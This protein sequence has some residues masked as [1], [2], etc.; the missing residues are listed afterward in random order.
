MGIIDITLAVG[1]S[2]SVLEMAEK[3]LR[4]LFHEDE[5][6]PA[7][8]VGG[9]TPICQFKDFTTGG[10]A[11]CRH[12]VKWYENVFRW[13]TRVRAADVE[14]KMSELVRA[15]NVGFDEEKSGNQSSGPWLV[16]KG[17]PWQPVIKRKSNTLV[18]NS[19]VVLAYL[20]MAS[21]ARAPPELRD[22]FLKAAECEAQNILDKSGGSFGCP[23]H[24]S[25]LRTIALIQDHDFERGSQRLFVREPFG[26]HD[27]QLS[28]QLLDCVPECPWIPHKSNRVAVLAVDGIA[29]DALSPWHD[30]VSLRVLDIQ[31]QFL[32]RGGS[33]TQDIIGRR[34][35][36][37]GTSDDAING[38]RGLA[39]SYDA[40]KDRYQVELGIVRK[41]DGPTSSTPK[42]VS[43]RAA[44]V[45]Q[46]H[47]TPPPRT[48]AD[49]APVLRDVAV[50]AFGTSAPSKSGI[51]KEWQMMQ[52]CSVCGVT[53]EANGGKLSKCAK[54]RYALYCSHECQVAGW[55]THRKKCKEYSRIHGGESLANVSRFIANSKGILDARAT[56]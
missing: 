49:A 18:G 23:A 30:A 44:C 48:V 25:R 8:W 24:V 2:D 34:V 33:I 36:V 41:A 17:D 56:L 38:R 37:S 51:R 28:Y 21:G 14:T 54:C 15:A 20:F 4:V 19:Y 42:V 29:P 43:L 12:E 45:R 55:K 13:W 47:Y 31:H 27:V 32:A 5:D 11:I 53:A 6:F 26:H 9:V 46:I 40:A 22:A 7:D 50:Y 52:K 35:L 16:D 3:F 10:M 1:T 39:T